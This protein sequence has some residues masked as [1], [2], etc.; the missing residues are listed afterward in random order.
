MVI[1]PFFANGVF[2]LSNGT[3]EPRRAFFAHRR[4]QWMLT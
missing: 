1:V 4:L 3:T 2:E